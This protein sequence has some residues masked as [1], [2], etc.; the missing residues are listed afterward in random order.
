VGA[1]GC[2]VFRRLGHAAC[3]YSTIDHSVSAAAT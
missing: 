3:R 2:Q 1:A